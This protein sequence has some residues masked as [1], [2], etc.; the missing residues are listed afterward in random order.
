[1]KQASKILAAALVTLSLTA[2]GGTDSSDE[3]ELNEL[4]MSVFDAEWCAA[5]D[6]FYGGVDGLI[7]S[8]RLDDPQGMPEEAERL[9]RAAYNKC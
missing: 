7:E 4:D 1:M 2:C 5:T 6:E 9:V 8:I 3:P